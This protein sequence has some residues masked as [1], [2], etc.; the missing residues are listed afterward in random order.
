PHTLEAQ[1]AK[2]IDRRA[3]DLVV[4]V[5]AHRGEFV[6]QVRAACGYDGDI[7]S[8]EPTTRTYAALE[9]LVQADAR[10]SAHRMALGAEAG[11]GTLHTSEGSVFNSLH[12]ASDFGRRSYDVLES[13]TEETVAVARCDD[14]LPGLVPD[15]ERRSILLKAD[16]QG[17]DLEV[18]AGA[19][20]TMAH[21]QALLV[22]VPVQNLYEDV[23]DFLAYLE[24]LLATGLQLAGL[25]PV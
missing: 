17:H 16:T 9:P 25:F 3:I 7:I 24:V 19:A 23:P 5:G 14:V 8:F 13:E 18:L 15:W 12:D 10:W 2:A 6:H 20:S 11:E 21:V 4:D 1:L 22:E